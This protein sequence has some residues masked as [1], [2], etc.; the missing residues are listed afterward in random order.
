MGAFSSKRYD[1]GITPSVALDNSGY[2]VEVH[3]SHTNS[4]LWYRVAFLQN[5][6]TWAQRDGI[7]W[8]HSICYGSGSHPS[9]ALNDVGTLIEVHES[10]G[11]GKMLECRVGSLD[12]D[13]A[14]VIWSSSLNLEP[15]KCPRVSLDNRNNVVLVH[16]HESGPFLMYRIGHIDTLART[17]KFSPIAVQ[18]PPPRKALDMSRI[19][20]SSLDHWQSSFTFVGVRSAFS[21]VTWYKAVEG[22]SF[23]PPF[24]ME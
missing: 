15:G 12:K 10:A 16:Q 21:Q 24:I 23:C 8:G 4:S 6:T 3:Q 18:Y 14:S 13:T 2:A 1:S 7:N 19:F 11:E 20:Y 22:A 5:P 17:L 9:V